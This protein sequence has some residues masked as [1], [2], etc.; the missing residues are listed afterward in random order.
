M[1][2]GPVWA[3]E[4]EHARSTG[5][6]FEVVEPGKEFDQRHKINYYVCQVRRAPHP[7]SSQKFFHFI[8]SPTAGNIYKKFGFLP[9]SHRHHNRNSFCCFIIALASVSI[10]CIK[11][12]PLRAYD[13]IYRNE[14]VENLGNRRSGLF[15][16]F[17]SGIVN[18]SIAFYRINTLYIIERCT[19]RGADCCSVVDRFSDWGY[20]F[21]VNIILK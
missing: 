11:G 12:I 19:E 9:H 20:R 10:L 13:T 5:L 17:D 2:V 8:C 4:A 16:D 15:T 6:A 21:K 18:I 14:P 1:D 3:T 7:D